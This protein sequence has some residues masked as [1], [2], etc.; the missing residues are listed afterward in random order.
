MMTMM[1]QTV[2]TT[3]DI[4]PVFHVKVSTEELSTGEEYGTP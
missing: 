4:G 3:A 1:H 2:R